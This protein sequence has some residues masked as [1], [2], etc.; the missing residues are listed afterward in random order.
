MKLKEVIETF[1]HKIVG[2]SEFTWSCYGPNV[3]YLDFESDFAYT[4]CLFEATTQKVFEVIVDKK[5]SE[6]Q[7]YRWLNPDTKQSFINECHTRKVEY[8]K[9]WDS[10]YYIDLEV[11][12]DF[13]TKAKAIFNNESYDERVV[14]PVDLSDAE[15]LSLARLAHDR[16]IT[17]NK[18]VEL[19]L[20]QAID[21]HKSTEA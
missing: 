19:V 3:R 6:K 1:D 21:D 14:V 12:E 7:P 10:V 20:Q 2:G 4:G 13:L 11:D 16:D 18:M 5:D 9:A 8:N 15:F 17:I